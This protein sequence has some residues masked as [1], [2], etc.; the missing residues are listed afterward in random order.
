MHAPGLKA[1]WQERERERE[2]AALDAEIADMEERLARLAEDRAKWR[3]ECDQKIREREAEL[4]ELLAKAKA[5]REYYYFKHIWIRAYLLTNPLWKIAQ[6]WPHTWVELSK[7]ESYGFYPR[8]LVL[9]GALYPR[10]V[11]G[12]INRDGTGSRDG[13]EDDPNSRPNVSYRP[14]RRKDGVLTHGLAVGKACADASESEVASC[15]RAVATE[16]R[17]R[18]RRWSASPLAGLSDNCLTFVES[19]MKRCCMEP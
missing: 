17:L 4:P 18:G 11:P 2:T 7:W 8:A 12:M 9:P 10:G 6:D 15:V 16:W 3:A 1:Q 19:V 14:R 13:A 5:S